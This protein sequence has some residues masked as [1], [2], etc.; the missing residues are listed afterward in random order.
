[1]II[2]CLDLV[3][4]SSGSRPDLTDPDRQILMDCGCGHMMIGGIYGQVDRIGGEVFSAY[5]YVGRMWDFVG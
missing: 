4:F 3:W 1:M 2:Y 5:L